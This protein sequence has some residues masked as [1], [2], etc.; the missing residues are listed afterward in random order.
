MYKR[1]DVYSVPGFD[2]PIVLY[3]RALSLGMS[4]EVL[5]LADSI[6]ASC[7]Q[8]L[9]ERR[10]VASRIIPFVRV[11]FLG[12]SGLGITDT[13]SF[14]L[15]VNVQGPQSPQGWHQDYVPE[16]GVLYPEGEGLIEINLSAQ[17]LLEARNGIRTTDPEYMAIPVG[18]G[19]VA[20]IGCGF[21]AFHRGRNTTDQL[22]RTIVLHDLRYDPIVKD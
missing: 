12:S 20:I 21:D 19:D 5:G 14:S 3:R 8:N 16:A 6:G 1:T 4:Q 9:G 2:A 18:E 10:F 7:T 11:D 17:N 15:R 22:R 13:N